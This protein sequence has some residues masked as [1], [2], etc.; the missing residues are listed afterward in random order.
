MRLLHHVI[1]IAVLVL[2]ICPTGQAQDSGTVI[3]ESDCGQWI[4]GMRNPVYRAWLLGYVS[5]LN[6]GVGKQYGNPLGK[7]S[8]AEQIYVWMDNYCRANPLRT[9]S[10]GAQTLYAELINQK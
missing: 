3:G 2:L 6:S 4:K 10:Q 5:G 8:S 7:I 1:A 9:L